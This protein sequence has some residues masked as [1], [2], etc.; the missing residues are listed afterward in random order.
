ME[1]LEL[2][3]L[4][5]KKVFV[6]LIKNEKYNLTYDETLVL[7]DVL[8]KYDFKFSTITVD[9]SELPGFKETNLAAFLDDSMLTCYN[10]DI[11]EYAKGY[12]DNE[13]EE[14]QDRLKELK[15]EYNTLKDK[16]SYNAQTIKSWIDHLTAELK[17]KTKDLNTGLRAQ[18]VVKKIL[19]IIRYYEDSLY[20]EDTIYILHFT[21]G[22]L[23][24]ALKDLFE[25]LGV[26]VVVGEIKSRVLTHLYSS[27]KSEVM[28]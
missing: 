22:E 15:A 4:K 3:P 24:M 17:E 6:F 5:N 28:N 2:K 27:T 26:T 23:L 25:Q 18:W 10:V 1:V 19:D 14:E 13:I 8:E 11:P 21:S 20:Y 12:L 16:D 7:A 9:E